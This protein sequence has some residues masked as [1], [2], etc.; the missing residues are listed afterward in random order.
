MD[1]N[2]HSPVVKVV[3]ETG[4]G[5]PN[6]QPVV[7][8]RGPFVRSC[9]EEGVRFAEMTLAFWI[10]VA[11]LVFWKYRWPGVERFTQVTWVCFVAGAL[12]FALLSRYGTRPLWVVQLASTSL[13]RPLLV[14]VGAFLLSP[15]G[16]EAELRSYWY[17][18]VAVYLVTLA[19]ESY[20]LM[21]VTPPGS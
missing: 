12:V 1:G 4:G 2:Q 16:S 20:C 10:G 13:T 21:R 3:P 8:D 15:A 11:P 17:S 6:S 5:L 9:R 19:M 14:G 18:V 7:E